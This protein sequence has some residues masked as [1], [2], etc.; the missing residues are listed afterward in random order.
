MKNY[1]YRTIIEKDGEQYHGYVPALLGCHTYGD[2]IEETQKNLKEA[3]SAYIA[4]FSEGEDIPEDS[5]FES[6]IT[7]PFTPSVFSQK[8]YA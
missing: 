7:I 1:T 8:M 6:F 2:S 5:S 4:S 3:I